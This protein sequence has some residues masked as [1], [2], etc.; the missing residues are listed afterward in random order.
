LARRAL[1]NA[2]FKVVQ[3]LELGSLEPYTDA[4]LPAAPWFE[5]EATATTWEG[6]EQR[7]RP[8]RGPAGLS[9]P[10]WEIFDELARAMGRDLGLRSLDEVREELA[11]LLAPRAPTERSTAWAGAGEPQWIDG[12]TLFTYPLLVDE[13]RL[14][15]G[16]SELKAALEE[17]PFAEVHPEDAEAHGLV[18]GG[19]V[20]LRTSSGE[21]VV[22]V[23]VT[24]HVAAGSVF[25]PYDQPGLAA[26]TLLAGRFTAAVELQAAAADDGA[27]AP[28]VTTSV[29][30]ESS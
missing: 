20:R 2:P 13:G 26:N 3:S 21:A 27:V 24:E 10:D 22:P 5:R 7:L 30:G 16:A 11:G 18:D 14:S 19:S 6:R 29:G 28:A 25:V 17:T 15:E 23:R 9:R 4:F 12:L 1:E 8:A